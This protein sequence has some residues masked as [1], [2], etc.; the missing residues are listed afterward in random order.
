M[1]GANAVG[2]VVLVAPSRAS[3]RRAER[4]GLDGQD[5]RNREA[6]ER[7][8]GA[9]WGLDVPIFE[10]DGAAEE[11]GPDGACCCGGAR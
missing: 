6:Y 4:L 1:L 9:V 2:T 5:E 7:V 8:S 11:G 10:Y 3:V